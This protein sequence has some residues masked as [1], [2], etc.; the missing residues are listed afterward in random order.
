MKTQLRNL[1]RRFQSSGKE[2]MNAAARIEDNAPVKKYPI[3]AVS[4]K[5][6]RVKANADILLQRNNI[7]Q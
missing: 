7:I 6:S 2:Q 1:L 4:D 5:N 3:S